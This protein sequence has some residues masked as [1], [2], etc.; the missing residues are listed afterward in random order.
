MTCILQYAHNHT[1]WQRARK[2]SQ[3]SSIVIAMPLLSQRTESRNLFS[4]YLLSILHHQHFVKVKS[5]INALGEMNP[6]QTTIMALLRPLQ[7]APIEGARCKCYSRWWI[8]PPVWAGAA[9]ETTNCIFSL[10]KEFRFH[11]SSVR[12]GLI[13]R[14]HQRCSTKAASLS[15]LTPHFRILYKVMLTWH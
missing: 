8:Q 13:P 4:C 7:E 12:T 11:L 9:D 3:A 14:A 2:H 10:C 15:S 6:K 5:L 1:V